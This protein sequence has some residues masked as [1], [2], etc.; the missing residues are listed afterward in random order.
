[1][2]DKPLTTEPLPRA[3][4]KTRYYGLDLLRL[5]WLFAI[6]YFHTLETFFYSNTYDLAFGASLFSYFQTPVRALT[7]SGFAIV[8]LS[9]FLL[10]W[11]TM[12]ARKWISLMGVLALGA[13]FLSWLEG[14]ENQTFYIQWDIYYFHFASF[15]LIAILQVRRWLLYAVSALFLPLLFIPVW[16]WDSS[17]D[18][19]GW[20]KD[21]L[22]GD[23]TLREGQG[24]WPLFPWLAIPL[25]MYSSAKFIR[26][27]EHLKTWVHSFSW[28]EALGW[29]VVLGALSP[30]L[31]GYFFTPIG[32][33]FS[34]Y[35]HRRPPIEF[36]SQWLWV[37][38]LIRLS[39]VDRLNDE[40][41]RRRW[42]RGIS[43]MQWS[44]NM[45]LAY[46][47]H[48]VFLN[49]GYRWVEIY[50]SDQQWIDVFFVFLILGVE[51]LCQIFKS[52]T[53]K[54]SHFRWNRL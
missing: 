10:G 47:L 4:Y 26:S 24:S 25:A 54:F 2:S 16:Q 29:A 50:K 5:F 23:C 51:S 21:L 37:I 46:A 43:Q 34:C 1:M 32:S 31:G 44:Q 28:K 39:L 6:I 27:R 30:W 36:W 49:L 18:T 52:F 11:I 13:L 42:V 35:V 45:G 7:F 33:Q 17:L 3:R 53:I 12:D 8:S 48:F 9:S 20:W 40:L 15:A 14:D 19:W 38:L 41:A 22:L